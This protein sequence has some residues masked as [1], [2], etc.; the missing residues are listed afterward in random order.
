M[1]EGGWI[2]ILALIIYEYEIWQEEKGR[3][4]LVRGWIDCVWEEAVLATVAATE[5]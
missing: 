4:G 5:Y 3:L 2:G 1:E